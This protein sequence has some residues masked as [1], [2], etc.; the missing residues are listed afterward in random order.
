MF[1]K[2]TN[3]KG[4][5][6]CND[7]YFNHFLEFFLTTKTSVIYSVFLYVNIGILNYNTKFHNR[8]YLFFAGKLGY[9]RKR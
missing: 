5:F 3:I 9:F 8:V 2:I 4:V 1:I 7:R 6:L